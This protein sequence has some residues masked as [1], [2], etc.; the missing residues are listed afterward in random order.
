MNFSELPLAGVARYR[1]SGSNSSRSPR[2]RSEVE[3]LTAPFDGTGTK[4]TIYRH[5]DVTHHAITGFE[6]AWPYCL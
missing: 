4:L 3:D 6:W 1:L 5:A 2:S